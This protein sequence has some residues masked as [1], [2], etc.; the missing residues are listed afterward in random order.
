MATLS[1]VTVSIPF[2]C[3]SVCTARGKSL[4]SQQQ[5]A[6]LQE[7]RAVLQLLGSEV[8]YPVIL[9]LRRL[10]GCYKV[11]TSLQRLKARP[12][13]VFILLELSEIEITWEWSVRKAS[14]WLCAQ[15]WIS[16][17]VRI[18]QETIWSLERDESAPAERQIR[19][20]RPNEAELQTHIETPVILAS[21]QT[22]GMA[23]AFQLGSL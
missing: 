9:N 19:K 18:K 7:N 8:N 14:F 21:A 4:K 3:M 16:L 5:D 20:L 2:A 6:V 1:K 12:C 23:Y 15:A 10:P 22:K 13:Y 11:G 17:E